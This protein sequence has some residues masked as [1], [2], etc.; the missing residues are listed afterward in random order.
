MKSWAPKFNKKMVE[1]MRK[2]QFKS[3]NSE[4]FNGFKQI[5]FNQQQ[6]LMKNEI[7]KK[8]EI[9]VV[10]SF[11]ERT[12]FSVI[13]RNEHN[14]FFYAIDKNVQNEVS[15]KKLRALFDK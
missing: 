10:T 15:V 14:E 6:D 13:G 11:N 1:V 5:D 12:I 9:K 8:Y 4:D 2:N 3:D 7:S